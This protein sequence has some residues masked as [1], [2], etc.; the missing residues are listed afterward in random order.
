MKNLMIS[1]IIKNLDNSYKFIIILTDKI[2]CNVPERVALPT[3]FLLIN[4]P[5][6]LFCLKV[7]CNE[8]A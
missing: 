7:F 4:K 8:I 5:R 6:L 1:I 2:A 3:L